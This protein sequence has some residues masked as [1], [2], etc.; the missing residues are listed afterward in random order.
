M[1]F[2]A[3]NRPRRWMA[4]IFLNLVPGVVVSFFDISNPTLL[5]GAI[6]AVSVLFG[7][8]YCGFFS[9]F[10][11]LAFC[12]C[13]FSEASTILNFSEKN[14]ARLIEI[15]VYIV[16]IYSLLGYYCYQFEKRIRELEKA[17]SELKQLCVL[18]DL[19][20]IANR[21]FFNQMLKKE[22]GRC[23]REKKKL[24]FLMMDVDFFKKYNDIYGHPQGDI[25]L[26]KIARVIQEKCFRP[27]DV[28]A[29][30]GGEEFACLL[31]DT[32]E[33]GAKYVAEILRQEVANLQ[34]VHDGSSVNE[35]ITIS[36]GLITQL[37]T[38]Q[39]T[40]KEMIR[41]ADFALYQAKKNGRN[42]IAVY[43]NECEQ[44]NTDIRW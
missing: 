36:V 5:L 40:I 20:G 14:F 38:A 2:Y 26:K 27:G 7:G 1:K 6:Q 23:L 4:C 15:V 28:V 41:R 39:D 24:S 30:Y 37:P 34:I 31:P 43:C 21:R 16:M 22:W 9:G 12:F 33:N 10:A 44:A 32:D 42:R 11:S 13:Y 18:D 25:C 35:Y 19:T 17:N 8:L 3:I 29:R